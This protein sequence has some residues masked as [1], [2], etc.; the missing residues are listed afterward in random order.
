LGA[1]PNVNN[2]I[3]VFIKS[4]NPGWKGLLAAVVIDACGMR[5]QNEITALEKSGRPPGRVK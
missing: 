4:L 3:A 1:T 2:G 5:N